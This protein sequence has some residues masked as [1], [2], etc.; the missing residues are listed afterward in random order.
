MNFF[1]K[2]TLS[3]TWKESSTKLGAQIIPLVAGCF[4]IYENNSSEI[5]FFSS[6]Q[7]N[8]R[9]KDRAALQYLLYK[10]GTADLWHVHQII[11][12]KT[13]CTLDGTQL[14]KKI[15]FVVFDRFYLSDFQLAFLTRESTVWK[16]ADG[17]KPFGSLGEKMNVSKNQM[18]MKLCALWA[19]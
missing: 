1:S 3:S 8:Y 16:N 7:I 18:E 17:R 14:Q 12:N 19:Y 15:G 4:V 10:R 6:M 5:V 9:K 11:W 2:I 13:H